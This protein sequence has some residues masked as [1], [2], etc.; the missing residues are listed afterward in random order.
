VTYALVGSTFALTGPG[1]F[2]VDAVT[3]EVFNRPWMRALAL[4]VLGH[5][6]GD[7][8]AGLL[9]WGRPPGAVEMFT[10]SRSGGLH[11]PP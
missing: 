10:S 7:T 9:T 6:V 1:R 3:G 2:S 4:V 8:P 11:V 5:E